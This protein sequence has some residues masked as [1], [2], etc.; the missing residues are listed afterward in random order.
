MPGAADHKRKKKGRMTCQGH[1]TLRAHCSGPQAQ[2]NQEHES[3]TKSCPQLSHVGCF[4]FGG[5]PG[6]EKLGMISLTPAI[7]WQMHDLA[8]VKNMQCTLY[9]CP[10]LT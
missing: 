3:I 2:T 10:N 9:P 5:R 1:A 6:R 8:L 4:L 7:D